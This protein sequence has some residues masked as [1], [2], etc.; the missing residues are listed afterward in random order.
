MT[1]VITLT[2]KKGGVGKTVTTINLAAALA[3]M[4]KK[5]L[6][7]D[8]D[9]RGNM[10]RCLLPLDIQDKYEKKPGSHPKS[11]HLDDLIHESTQH[12]VDIIPAM[13]FTAAF[14]YLDK[15]LGTGLMHA[16]ESCHIEK[17]DYILIDSPSEGM[18]SGNVLFASDTLII[19]V[20]SSFSI[21]LLPDMFNKIKFLKKHSTPRIN[22]VHIL[23]TFFDPDTETGKQIR[24]QIS[25]VRSDFENHVLDTEIP[26]DPALRDS[27]NFNETIFTYDPK[28]K[29]AEAYMALAEE[30]IRKLESDN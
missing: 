19:P 10:T 28:S 18:M 8:A 6:G 24:K 4:N 30:L 25:K 23:I 1:K 16:L 15:L 17:Y 3:Q 14:D 26:M 22:N 5:I 29:G 27:A 9:E 12:N 13:N 21:D 11:K 20:E 2:N 7:I